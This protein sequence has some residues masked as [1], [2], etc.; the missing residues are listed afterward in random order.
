MLIA[1]PTARA[2]A[3]TS[4]ASISF[5]AFLTKVLVAERYI[6]LRIRF[7]SARRAARAADFV[8]GKGHLLLFA[9]RHAYTCRL[10]SVAG[11]PVCVQYHCLY[12]FLGQQRRSARGILNAIQGM[13]GMRAQRTARFQYREAAERVSVLS[14]A[15]VVA[16]GF[17]LSRVLGLVREVLIAARFGTSANYDAYVAAFRLPDFLFLVVMSG[18]F[19]SAFIPVFGGLLARGET[20]RAWRLANTILT[21]TLVILAIT[22]V[23][24]YLAA[25]PLIRTVVAPGLAPPQQALAVQLTRL[26][27][28]SPL[29]LGLGA[30]GKG[31]LEAQ[32][33]FAL[34]A[35]AP[36][37]YNL[38]II[39]G[40]A[41]LAPFFGIYGL[42]YGVVL[43]ALG[44]MGLQFLAL[45]ANGWRFIPTWDLHDPHVGEVARLMGPRVIGQAA[46]QVNMIVM[47]NFASRLGPQHVSSLNYAYQLFMLPHGVLAL[48]LSTVIFPLMAQDVARGLL[49]R[50]RAMLNQ[51]LDALLLFTLPASAGLLLFRT[52]IV[53]TLFQFGAFS[54]TSTTL[55]AEALAYMAP[56]LLAFAV[57]EAVT[58][59]FYALHDT[60][61]PVTVAVVAVAVNALLC[62]LFASP[63]GNRGIALALTLSTTLE[64]AILLLIL[65]QR[66]H[67]FGAGLWSSFGK[68]LLATAVMTII[69]WQF[70]GP[71]AQ[72][73]NPTDGRSLMQP[74]VLLYTCFALAAA[75]FV[76]AVLLRVPAAWRMLEQ[77]QRIAARRRR[78]H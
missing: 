38:G 33:R 49:D 51:S 37:L 31:M 72:V 19:G 66:L 4:P 21:F 63:L 24:V 43:G 74:L 26:L 48:S 61:T 75:Y 7:F 11:L 56:G 10:A 30:A 70:A 67:G 12:R 23:I 17:V 65:R 16:L 59:A 78:Y 8:F 62:A 25:G 60:R 3:S 27:L 69:G 52:S 14:S 46:F 54:S 50:A 68:M 9:R 73:T 47:T 53:Q 77:A 6:R 1:S 22:G 15:S 76:T 28:L 71:L 42:A 13:G 36:V 29:L 35:F 39:V 64:M 57:V 44:H 58:R 41:V 18:A 45:Y 2:A 20:Q 5:R 55:V 32:A 40:A 34:P